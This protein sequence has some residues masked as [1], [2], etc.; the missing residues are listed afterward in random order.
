V[1]LGV[2]TAGVVLMAGLAGWG[3]SMIA[4]S[5]ADTTAAA[6]S[7]SAGELCLPSARPRG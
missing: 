7:E 4:L 1:T 5:S 2:A 6:A 3:G